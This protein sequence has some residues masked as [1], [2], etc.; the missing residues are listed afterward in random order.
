MH[1]HAPSALALLFLWLVALAPAAAQP[2]PS[3]A[4]A[5]SDPEPA[6]APLTTAAPPAP[7]ALPVDNKLSLRE[8]I[9]RATR[10]FGS[11]DYD[12]AIAELSLAYQRKPVAQFL[13]NIAQAHR[14]AGRFR[15]ALSFYER[16]VHDDL[17]SPLLPEAQAHAAAMRAR[18]DAELA[19]AEREAAERVARVRAEEAEAMAKA[20]EGDRVRAE[21]ELRR[22]LAQKEAPV[23]KRKWFW[24]LLGGLVAAAVIT[25]VTVGVVLKNP[26]EPV[27]TLETQTLRF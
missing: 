6:P 10:A 23:Y 19:T 27:G 9:D 1:R 8:L 26:P 14:K 11:G 7:A 24:G 25:G 22:A 3:S 5:A 17:A 2:A 15:E 12:T 16:F 20:R 13:F 21:A 18:L 4:A